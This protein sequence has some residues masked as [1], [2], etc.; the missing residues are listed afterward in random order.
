MAYRHPDLRVRDDLLTHPGTTRNAIALRTNLSISTVRTSLL[1]LPV[2]ESSTWPRTYRLL[3]RHS[4]RVTFPTEGAGAAWQA[5][6]AATGRLVKRLDLASI[7]LPYEEARAELVALSELVTS[8]IAAMDDVGN[9]PEWRAE[10]GV[11]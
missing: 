11:V 6:R 2:E 8:V 9:V 10:I 4:V 1:A 7:K 5:Q 3:P